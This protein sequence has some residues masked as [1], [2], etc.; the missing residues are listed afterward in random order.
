M[1]FM[2]V[3]E[4]AKEE[5][6]W[7]CSVSVPRHRHNLAS[8]LSI[9]RLL[10]E[11]LI[12]WPLVANDQAASNKRDISP[13]CVV[14]TD[15]SI[16][17][18]LR[19]VTS[20]CERSKNYLQENEAHHFGE[21]RPAMER[22]GWVPPAKQPQ[23]FFWMHLRSAL[24]SFRRNHFPFQN[25]RIHSFASNNYSSHPSI[26]AQV[27]TKWPCNVAALPDPHI[28]FSIMKLTLRSSQS[29]LHL[30]PIAKEPRL[31]IRSTCKPQNNH[32]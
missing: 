2:T 11:P 8:F 22:W 18:T 30:L 12:I 1:P 17:I 13:A 32:S 10:Q 20:P 26:P 25:I 31:A 3:A 4:S 23:K 19:H 29:L 21:D 7:L 28:L 27:P 14:K 24:R 9:L 5:F 15:G 6:V 16:A